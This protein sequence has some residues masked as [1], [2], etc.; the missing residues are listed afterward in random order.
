M[1]GKIISGEGRVSGQP[2]GLVKVG[3]LE[4]IIRAK[5]FNTHIKE[6]D[7]RHRQKAGGSPGGR[8]LFVSHGEVKRREHW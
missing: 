8:L 1:W 5:T 2:C 4:N 3:V 6:G 7:S